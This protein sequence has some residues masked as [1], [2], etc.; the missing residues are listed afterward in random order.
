MYE[1]IQF[2]NKF[3]YCFYA[4]LKRYAGVIYH[5]KIE[6]SV[7]SINIIDEQFFTIYVPASP[8]PTHH[9]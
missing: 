7:F 1:K 4:T 9:A 2:I 6:R 5:K 3:Y 8:S